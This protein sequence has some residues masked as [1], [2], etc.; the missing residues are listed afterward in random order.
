MPGIEGFMDTVK[1]Y[2]WMSVIY[3]SIEMIKT[4]KATV[5]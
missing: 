1:L 2:S 3:A 5:N 4:Y